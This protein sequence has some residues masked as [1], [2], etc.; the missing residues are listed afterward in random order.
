[1]YSKEN[2]TIIVAFLIKEME[3][4]EDRVK[5]FNL[6]EI[7]QDLHISVREVF[8]SRVGRDDYYFV[9][10]TVSIGY[11]KEKLDQYLID[12][13]GLGERCIY[14]DWGYTSAYNMQLKI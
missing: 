11:P 6:P 7:L 5:Q 10:K 1:M 2:T 13:I 9:Y 8:R 4:I 14:E 12:Y 3:I